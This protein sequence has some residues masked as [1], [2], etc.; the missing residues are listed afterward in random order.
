MSDPHEERKEEVAALGHSEAAPAPPAETTASPATTPWRGIAV[1]LAG[2]LLVAVV[3][4]GT[5]PFWAASLPWA[6]VPSQLPPDPRIDRLTTEQQQERQRRLQDIAA[7]NAARQKLEDRLGALETRDAPPADAIAQLARRVAALEAKPSVSPGDIAELREQTAKASAATAALAARVAAL[8]QSVHGQAATD[9]AD[10]AIVLVLLQIRDALEIGRPFAAEYDALAA[11]ARPHPEIEAAAQPLA[12]PAK[13]G[14][15]GRAVLAGQLP[16]LRAAIAVSQAAA[17]P[18]ENAAPAAG[19][20]DRALSRLRG[21]VTIRRID[22]STPEMPAAT[23]SGAAAAPI[24]VAARALAGGDLEAAIGALDK[25]TGPPAEAAA[26]WLRMGKQRLAV[27]AALH[28]IEALLAARL[29]G[30]GNA[31]AVPGSPR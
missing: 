29:G 21:L 8:D 11:L 9:T 19:W 13:S 31:A 30:A 12:E 5:A 10:T 16:E 18:A 2:I 22:G 4:V 3:L 25:L 14:V 24:D 27:E 1:G 17:K 26:A 23:L 7:A 6:P 15:A 28:R 20:T